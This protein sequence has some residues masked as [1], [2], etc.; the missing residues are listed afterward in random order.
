MKWVLEKEMINVII[1]SWQIKKLPIT[2]ALFKGINK[3][4]HLSTIPSN[5]MIYSFLVES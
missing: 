1:L 3:K 2:A 5:D 4:Y